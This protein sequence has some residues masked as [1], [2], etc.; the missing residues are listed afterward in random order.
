MAFA[1]RASIPVR[2]KLKSIAGELFNQAMTNSSIVNTLKSLG[3]SSERVDENKDIKP[4][5]VSSYITG[6]IHNL[7]IS[8]VKEISDGYQK[9]LINKNEDVFQNFIDYKRSN[10]TSINCAYIDEKENIYIGGKFS[11]INDV[12][13]NNVAKWNSET[14]EWSA[15]DEEGNGPLFANEDD[16]VTSI[17]ILEDIPDE[18]YIAGK[19]QKISND[20]ICN[21][22]IKYNIISGEWIPLIEG[23]NSKINCMIEK[24]GA[25]YIG[26]TF[27]QEVQVVSGNP[28]K[29]HKIAKWNGNEWK[30]VP[31]S[32]SNNIPIDSNN[33]FDEIHDIKIDSNNNIYVCGNGTT[34]I[35]YPDVQQV[36]NTVNDPEIRHV[37]TQLLGSPSYTYTPETSTHTI[38]SQLV[39]NVSDFFVSNNFVMSGD[40]CLLNKS[41]LPDVYNG[42]YKINVEYVIGEDYMLKNRIT[43]TKTADGEYASAIGYTFP[44]EN[45]AWKDKYI[46]T[47][48]K[49]YQVVFEGEYIN[50]TTQIGFTLN[51]GVTIY[52]TR[53]SRYNS[54]ID[55][56]EAL[57]AEQPNDIVL[58]ID[59]D[60][61]NNIVYIGGQFTS[62]SPNNPLMKVGKLELNNIES[63]WSQV[64]Q[65]LN[66]LVRKVRIDVNGL[67]YAAGDF[68]STN[69]NEG[70]LNKL[71]AWDG[72]KWMNISNGVNNSVISMY[73][74]T[75]YIIICGQF[76][77]SGGNSVYKFSKVTPANINVVTGNFYHKSKAY[78]TIEFASK[79]STVTMLWDKKEKYW[80]IV[81]IDKENTIL[82]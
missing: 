43:L 62:T 19:F 22:I 15:L 5:I 40:Y 56:F 65:G 80:D 69:D 77:E 49:Y 63:N 7:N 59:V 47:E 67:L 18:I 35:Q 55:E 30:K 45:E 41:Q 79:G 48:D 51:E 53:V 58:T 42:I 73:L 37:I 78:T 61:I 31:E 33:N 20:V 52:A 75:G 11:K 14:L 76:T 44:L 54:E 70:V 16:I 81:T 74:K 13:T 9:I 71:T 1:I 50:G 25:I 60:E 38:Q 10:V 21:N 17:L 64:G 68:T 6:S 39:D 72:T 28:N 2:S 3:G 26:G 12:E 46:K 8:K 23:L 32:L 24:D 66:S 34:F 82:M 27:T 36:I 4:N 29:L 57:G